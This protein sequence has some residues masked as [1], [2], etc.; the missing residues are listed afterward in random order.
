GDV[1]RG[2]TDVLVAE[3]H[4]RLMARDRYQL[5]FGAQNGD[6]GPLASDERLGQVESL[7]RQEGVQVVSGDPPGD[8][9]EV[10]AHALGMAVDELT[11]SP[12]DLGPS[13]SVLDDLLEF[14][15]RL[16]PHSDSCSVVGEVI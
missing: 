14:L 5:Q 2:R 7:L 13:S 6:E 12:V 1:V 16:S 3:H 9:R 15:V 10:V 4:H 11:Q 8:V